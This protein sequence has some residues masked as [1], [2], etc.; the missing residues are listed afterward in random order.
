MILFHPRS[1]IRKRFEQP[2]WYAFKGLPQHRHGSIIQKK[3]CE[4]L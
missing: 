3:V 4:V 1:P 2:D